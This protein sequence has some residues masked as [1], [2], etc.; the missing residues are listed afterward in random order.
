LTK[1]ALFMLDLTDWTNLSVKLMN[2]SECIHAKRI[3]YVRLPRWILPDPWPESEQEPVLADIELKDGIITRVSPSV[4]S[5]PSGSSMVFDAQGRLALPALIDAHTHLDKTYTR[6][7]IGKIKPGLLEAIQSMKNDARNWTQ[8]DLFQRSEQA[9]VRAWRHGVSL[10][11]THVDWIDRTPPL[12]WKVIGQQ[13]EKWQ[14]RIRIQRVALV[15]LPLFSSLQSAQ[16]IAKVVSQSH[17]SILGGF[18]HSSNFN[19]ASMYHLFHVAE[20]FN[21]DL[22][23]HI[24][25]ELDAANGLLWLGDYLSRHQFK[26]RIICG[27]ACGLSQLSTD[28]AQRLLSLFSHHSVTL[29]ALPATNLLLQDAESQRTPRHR[30][31][32][33]IH[34]AHKAGVPVLFASDNVRDAFCAYGDYNP[35]EALKLASYGAQLHDVFDQWS[36]SICYSPWLLEKAAPSTISLV[37]KSADL[38]LFDHGDT[39]RWPDYDSY[40]VMRNGLWMDRKETPQEVENHGD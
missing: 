4:Q 23:L 3:T 20:Q 16:C 38:L 7:R 18:I 24:D 35:I 30:G 19:A 33:T 17:G 22:D 13:A 12:A 5:K 40:Q 21:L 8:A 37:G 6:Q 1:L 29:V 26:G 2:R 15:P 14:D 36:Q 32:T 9:L 28:Q 27:H 25:E 31:L 11:R 34:E 10:L 39:S